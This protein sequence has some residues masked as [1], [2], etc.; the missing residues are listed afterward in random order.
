MFPFDGILKNE[1]RPGDESRHIELMCQFQRRASP[2]Q[3]PDIRKNWV[4]CTA[5]RAIFVG[6]SYYDSQMTGPSVHPINEIN[7]ENY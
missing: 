1:G 6:L 7:M 5:L 3:T 2:G 4:K